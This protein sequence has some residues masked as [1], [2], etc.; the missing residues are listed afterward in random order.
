MYTFFFQ[1][2]LSPLNENITKTCV[3]LLSVISLSLWAGLVCVHLCV[4]QVWRGMQDWRNPVLVHFHYCHWVKSLWACVPWGLIAHVVTITHISHNTVE[5]KS[6]LDHIRITQYNITH[7]S[8]VPFKAT[9]NI[10]MVLHKISY[11]EENN[12]QPIKQLIHFSW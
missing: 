9:L 1:C 8:V 12:L 7:A 11:F 3:G 6:G 4:R 10:Y 2:S 5:P